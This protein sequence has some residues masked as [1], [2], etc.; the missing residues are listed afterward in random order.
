MEE[1]QDLNRQP[2]NARP[3]NQSALT[4]GG[5]AARKAL[6]SGEDFIPGSPARQAELAIQ[7]EYETVG[8][9][10]IVARN[11]RRTQAIA[12]IY[13]EETFEAAING[14]RIRRDSYAKIALWAMR[15]ANALW[16]QD[17][18]EQKNADDG[19]I[20]AA[21]TSARQNRE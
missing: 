9:A 4:H 10:A 17:R 21:L 8:R 20:E 7:A 15:L 13:A 18:Q 3:G 5:A 19:S 12:D 1:A 16:E 14:D 6:S 11:A 2:N